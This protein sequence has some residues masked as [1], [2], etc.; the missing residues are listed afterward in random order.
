M[1][2]HCVI[3]CPLYPVDLIAVL[4]TLNAQV[5]S[6]RLTFRPIYA[7]ALFVILSQPHHNP[8]PILIPK[9]FTNADP[10]YWFLPALY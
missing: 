9:T 10:L 4:K 1:G 5:L 3:Y 2:Y 7:F 8:Q 6:N